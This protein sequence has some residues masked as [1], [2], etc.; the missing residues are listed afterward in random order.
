M[1]IEWSASWAHGQ[2]G[3]EGFR[4]G[5]AELRPR[6]H[7]QH[8]VASSGERAIRIIDNCR[9]KRAGGFGHQ[10]ELREIVALAR[11][12]DGEQQLVLKL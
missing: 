3:D 7:R 5:D 9:G 11:L 4:R 6:G 12:R 1:S 10:G 2:T 8:D